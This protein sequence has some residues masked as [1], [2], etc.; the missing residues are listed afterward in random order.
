MEEGVQ[1]LLH[2]QG[3]Q[4]PTRVFQETLLSLHGPS[5]SA[6]F[7]W[8]PGVWAIRPLPSGDSCLE[9]GEVQETDEALF[10]LGPRGAEW[11]APLSCL[12]V[13]PAPPVLLRERGG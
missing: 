1:P 8:V 2:P 7:V 11:E 13:V 4:S 10:H 5:Q 9:G 3:L 12:V 6:G